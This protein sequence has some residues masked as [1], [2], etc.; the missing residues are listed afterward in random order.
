MSSS[1]A[2]KENEIQIQLFKVFLSR[3]RPL[4]KPQKLCIQGLLRKAQNS[5]N[6]RKNSESTWEIRLR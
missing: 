1:S 3:P 4:K 6:S 2:N 5:K